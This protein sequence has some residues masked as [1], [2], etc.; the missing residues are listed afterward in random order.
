MQS[1]ATD[2]LL[3]ISRFTAQAFIAGLW[4]GLLLILAV[5]LCLRLLS[6]VSASVRFAVWAFAFALVV[7]VPLLHLRT[8]AVR[9]PYAPSAT[10]HLGAAWGF[11]IA[12][13]WALL[14][15]VH[16]VQFLMHAIRL[17]RIWTHARRVAAEGATLELLQ[18]SR[19]APALCISSDVDSPSVIGFFS[20]RLLIPESLFRKLTHSELQQIVLHECEHLRRCDDWTNLL[21]KIGIVLFPLN[22]ALLWVDRRLSLE[23]EL[24]CDA[25]VIA[26]TVAPFVY[27]SCLTRPAEHRLRCRNVALSLSAWSRQ[28][29]L[30][31]RV[32][33]LLRP[34]HEVSSLQAK[35]LVALLSLG[36]AGGAV[37]MARVPLFISF[38]DPAPAAA[39]AR[40]AKLAEPALSS[41]AMQQAVPVADRDATPAHA[42]LLKAVLPSAETPRTPQAR[43]SPSS[44]ARPTELRGG[45]AARLL[46]QPRVLLTTAREPSGTERSGRVSARLQ[47]RNSP[48]PVYALSTVFS[49]SYAAVPF[50]DGWLIIQL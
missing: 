14:T 27:A 7:A 40:V 49:P 6:R 35:S 45:H 31:R 32:A 48:R 13:T 24:A 30:A 46:Q 2:L 16:G 47:R 11:V 18:N 12:G 44:Q 23:R 38:A 37:E 50:A 33:S 5:A 15:A 8:V 19:R 42:T 28:S 3:D 4:Q 34:V 41:S 26:S 25:G 29:E 43:T 36:L 39:P 20:P 10:V 22:P 9:Q 1:A 21:L 17:R